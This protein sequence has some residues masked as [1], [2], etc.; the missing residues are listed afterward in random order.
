MNAFFSSFGDKYFFVLN[1]VVF[2]TG[3]CFTYKMVTEGVGSP[4]MRNSPIKTFLLDS[5]DTKDS[6]QARLCANST[7]S[8]TT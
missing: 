1:T 8:S 5:F 2:V 4:Y 6:I 3:R 7:A